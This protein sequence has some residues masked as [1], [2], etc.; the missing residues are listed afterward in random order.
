ME[1]GKTKYF[2]ERK[3]G[4]KRVEK[5]MVFG[6]AV[7]SS[8]YLINPSA[9]ILEFIPDNMPIIGN[10]DEGIAAALLLSC[11]RYFG[12]DITGILSRVR[13]E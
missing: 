4:K 7:I 2:K 1:S 5:A 3:K 9:G 13:R 11:L 6:V 8:I 12:I 10:L